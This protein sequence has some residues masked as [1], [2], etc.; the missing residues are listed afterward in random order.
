MDQLK[1][2][3]KPFVAVNLAE[4]FTNGGGRT[5]ACVTPSGRTK[6]MHGYAP[7]RKR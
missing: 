4:G 2:W 6:G 5:G 7:G 3:P 1:S